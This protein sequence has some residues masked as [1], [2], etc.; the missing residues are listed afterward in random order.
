MNNYDNFL[1][2]GG[3]ITQCPEINK[4]TDRSKI[5]KKREKAEKGIN[6][7][8]KICENCI[9]KIKRSCRGMCNPLIYVNGCESSRE[10]LLSDLKNQQYLTQDY[11]EI[12][13][14]LAEDLEYKKPELEMIFAIE[15]KRDRA[16][17]I[18]LCIGK[19]S[20]A[21]IANFFKFT[22]SWMSR[23]IK[24]ISFYSSNHFS[25]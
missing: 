2:L 23:M 10:I 24:Q 15:N 9:N 7:N 14:E 22:R 16:I 4:T 1:K 20:K 3:K 25:D 11:K 19:F 21:D 6:I 18:L 13:C 17:L 12:I 5:N 8:D